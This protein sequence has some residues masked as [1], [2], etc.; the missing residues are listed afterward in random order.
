MEPQQQG[1]DTLHSVLVNMVMNHPE[2]QFIIQLLQKTK[3][4]VSLS[5]AEEAQRA[6]HILA[7]FEI[8]DFDLDEADVQLCSCSAEGGPG[9]DC[10]PYVLHA[11]I[12]AGG[13]NAICQ[14][15]KA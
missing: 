15:L 4:L 11:F 6:K 8:L 10:L 2:N 12:L 7:L 9:I 3:A 1:E 13:R 14:I 5:P